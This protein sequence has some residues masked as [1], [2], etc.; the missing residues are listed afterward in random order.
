MKTLKEAV[1]Y[2]YNYIKDYDKENSELLDYDSL[3][4]MLE[5]ELLDIVEW[6]LTDGDMK[7]WIESKDDSYLDEVLNERLVDYP[8]LLQE[9]ANDILNE[10]VLEK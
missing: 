7:I 8:A 3:H 2:I 9:M 4:D 10:Y 5:E 1:D 6:A